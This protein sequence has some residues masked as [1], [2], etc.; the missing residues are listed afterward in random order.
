MEREEDAFVRAARGVAV[1]AD[2]RTQDLPRQIGTRVLFGSRQ[3]IFGAAD[4][5]RSSDRLISGAVHHAP[6]SHLM[7]D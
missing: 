7:G 6:P 1:P 2:G 4:E 3:A 5:A